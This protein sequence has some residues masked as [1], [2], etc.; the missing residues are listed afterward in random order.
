MQL[1]GPKGNKPLDFSQ[2]YILEKQADLSPTEPDYEVRSV[3]LAAMLDK[4]RLAAW[5]VE[6]GL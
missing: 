4:A 2:A 5:R 6:L 1:E 3:L